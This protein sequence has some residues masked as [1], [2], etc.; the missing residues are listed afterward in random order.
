MSWRRKSL[1]RLTSTSRPAS[2]KECLFSLSSPSWNPSGSGSSAVRMTGTPAT[3][4]SNDILDT[5]VSAQ[6]PPT[7]ESPSRNREGPSSPGGNKSMGPPPDASCS[8]SQ[9]TYNPRKQL[10]RR[11]DM[12]L[13]ANGGETIESHEFNDKRK[14]EEPHGG[15]GGPQSPELVSAQWQGSYPQSPQSPSTTPHNFDEEGGVGAVGS[16]RRDSGF[17]SYSSYSYR[18]DTGDFAPSDQITI[19]ERSA[20]CP[21]AISSHLRMSLDSSNYLGK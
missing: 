1:F 13:S 6:Q 9:P 12:C 5:T 3:D 14:C 17:S 20:T 15:P 11:K 8:S 18:G 2:A 7:A 10:L 21:D 16:Y 4:T 19:R